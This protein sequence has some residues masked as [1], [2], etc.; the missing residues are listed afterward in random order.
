MRCP[1][2]GVRAPSKSLFAYKRQCQE[3]KI[4]LWGIS[5]DG[6]EEIAKRSLLLLTADM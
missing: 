5:R 6:Q 3:Q 2:P 1:T 4:L